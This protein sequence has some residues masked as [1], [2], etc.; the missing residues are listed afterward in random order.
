[1]GI[2]GCGGIGIEGVAGAGNCGMSGAT[3]HGNGTGGIGCGIEGDV[4]GHGGSG[5]APE[6]IGGTPSGIAGPSG[7]T[8][9]VP[10]A[11]V[12]GLGAGLAGVMGPLGVLPVVPVAPMVPVVPLT[13]PGVPPVLPVVPLAP[14][15]GA[16]LMPPLMVAPTLLIEAA[17]R[18][19][20]SRINP[21]TSDGLCG[22]A[23]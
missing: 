15:L 8:P 11:P 23:T 16:G 1:M 10:D 22:G 18:N 5:Y 9:V 7:V 6:C 2:D 3:G 19:M 4:P 14:G 13:P 20:K 17:C 12:V 21:C